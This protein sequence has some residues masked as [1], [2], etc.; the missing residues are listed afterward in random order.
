MSHSRTGQCRPIAMLALLCG[1]SHLA[2]AATAF[3]AGPEGASV[4]QGTVSVTSGATNTI[5]NQTSN[6][7]LVDWRSFDT[8]AGHR[9]DVI[10][11]DRQSLLVNRVKGNGAATRFDGDLNAN[12]QVFLLNEAGIFIGA[13]ARINA[14]GF[15]ATTSG[16]DETSLNGSNIRFTAP[17]LTDA[18]VANAGVIRVADGGYAALAGAVVRN[19]GLI[20]ARLGR[21]TLAGSDRFEIDMAGDGLIRFALD[22]EATGKVL[23]G[24]VVRAAGGTVLLTARAGRDAM[25]GVINSTG[26]VE[27]QTA[28]ERDGR[29]II[30]GDA[31]T[32][33][34]LSGT[35]DASG[36]ATGQKGGSIDVTGRKVTL[37]DA[38]V[39]ADGDAGG[40][41]IRLGGDERGS[42]DMPHADRV[43][44][45]KTSLISADA[46]GNGDGGK[47]VVWSETH[48]AVTG[49]LTARGGAMGG[50]GGM[51]EV[52]SKG[53]LYLTGRIWLEA[54]KGTNGLFILDP[55]NIY[56]DDEA[57]LPVLTGDDEGV[58]VE[59]IESITAGRA[60][61]F[62][63]E[64][65]I[66]IGDIAD[67]SID[68][69]PDVTLRLYAGD[70][71]EGYGP[72]QIVFSSPTTINLS[73]TGG[74]DLSAP[75]EIVGD[76]TINGASGNIM[77]RSGAGLETTGTITS[78]GNISLEV[79]D[80]LNIR[81][82]VSTTGKLTLSGNNIAQETGALLTAGD[83]SIS[84]Y[85][86]VLLTE[87]GNSI[88][89]I[90]SLYAD[91]NADIRIS[92]G[93]VVL[94][95]TE[96]DFSNISAGDDLTIIVGN[97]NLSLAEGLLI[98]SGHD[99]VLASSGNVSIAGDV[100]LLAD[101][102]FLIYAR[103]QGGSDL[104][105]ITVDDTLTGYNFTSTPP[106][107]ITEP[108]NIVIYNVVGTLTV[109][110]DDIRITYGA[111]PSYTYSVTGFVG[112]DT[113][114]N[115]LTGTASLSSS[116]GANPGVGT[117]T[118]TTSAGSLATTKSYDFEFVAGTLTIDPATLTLI[119]NSTNRTY[120]QANPAFTYDISG[121]VNGDSASVVSGVTFTSATQASGVGTYAITASGGTAA[122]YAIQYQ[123]GSLTI[124]P[125]TLTVQVNNANR[126]YGQA[127]PA[128][129]Y[130][131]S[132][133]VNGDSASVVSG[134]TFN[135]DA[136]QASGVGTYAVTASGGTAANYTIQY[137]AGSLTIDPAALTIQVNN[138]RRTY[139]Q[140][141]PTFTYD[142][143]GL[144][145]GDSASVVSGVAFN[146]GATQAS[147]VGIYAVTASG[148]TA[149]NYTI[150]YQAGSLSIDPAALTLQINNANRTYGQANPAFAYEVSGLVNGDSASVVSGVAFN[151]SATQASGIGTYAV[152]ASG[153]TAANYTIQYQAGTLTIDPASLT[154]QVNNSRR[155]YGQ[156]NPAFAYDVSGLVNGDSASVVSGV[157]FNTSA[158][159]ASG[160]GTYAVT[161]SGGTAA[162]YTIQYQAGSLSIDPASLTLQVNNTR[163]TYGQANPA[164]AYDLSGLVN[165]DSAS[166]VSGVAFNTSATQASGVGT[167]AVT[168]SGGTAANYT[169]Q[170][171]AGILTIDPAALTLQVNNS[172]RTYG[173]DNPAL[174]YEV[175]GLVNGDSAS[176]VS[177]VTFNTSATQASGVG[178]YAVTASGGTA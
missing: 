72:Q 27:A 153:G 69:Q 106:S 58:S 21:V 31:Q 103:S 74:L 88:R 121:L 96:G 37:A 110:A 17:G 7:A 144:V 145:N 158:T 136:T 91:T 131:I 171:Q 174:A 77:V 43:A 28:V 118:I 149:A 163:R 141:N 109:K 24:G 23:N 94:G 148:G 164:F 73:G 150:Q 36:Q 127:N 46:T 169:I 4:V 128:F 82:T 39:N 60:E 134:V 6:R 44:I 8:D 14:A 166:V 99:I 42:G 168:A 101:N 15:L 113:A 130:D 124:D 19:E 51:V 68:M 152:T 142:V 2:M 165:G 170:Y 116:A 108:G 61:Y 151:T 29:I 13:N 175:S 25:A 155:T 65:N 97:G 89:R 83:L 30:T 139:G 146:T 133:L 102:R 147:G 32:D 76:F 114:G 71:V 137:Q 129:T 53:G 52:S 125:A 78:T 154:L 70:G 105:P 112:S 92:A 38:R 104:G 64:G 81:H 55:Q 1:V 80:D 161:A 63:F 5:I 49:T 3:A 111:T 172:R 34:S 33:I 123:A 18:I 107:S 159:Q 143:A 50:D 62:A 56:I 9:V 87:T 20:E 66:Y 98:T 22:S 26:V 90:S 160:V 100:E 79:Q 93:D 173:Q 75:G 67:G 16:I 45:D 177:G 120:G 40:G 156:A 95:K 48:T 167:Y 117:Y 132:G 41:V 126:T 138:T 10:Q 59:T 11:P 35:L 157:A 178:T 85:G 86:E 122:N 162:N 12:G 135:T 176:V 47:V 119:V 57:D 54:P 115:T 140:A 84:A